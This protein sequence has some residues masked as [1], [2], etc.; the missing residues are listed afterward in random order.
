M[1]HPEDEVRIAWTCLV[2]LVLIVLMAPSVHY[3]LSGRMQNLYGASANRIGLAFGFNFETGDYYE[4]LF[5]PRAR[6]I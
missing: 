2:L 6:R 5:A 4:V 1:S 3:T